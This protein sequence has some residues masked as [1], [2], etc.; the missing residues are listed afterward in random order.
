MIIRIGLVL[1]FLVIMVVSIRELQNKMIFM[2][3]RDK[4]KSLNKIKKIIDKNVEQHWIKT[5]DNEKL[6]SLYFKNN[7]KDTIIIYCHGNAGNI[8]SRLHMINVLKRYGS[9]LLFDYRGYGKSSGVPTEL[10]LKKDI[11]AVW[12]YTK[13]ELGYPAQNVVLYGE[14]LGC[15]PT[16]WLGKERKASDKPKCLILQSGFSCLKDIVSDIGPKFLENFLIYDFDNLELIKSIKADIPILIIHSPSDEIININHA[17]RL[18]IANR[19]VNFLRI[20]GTHNEPVFDD[21]YFNGIEK[22]INTKI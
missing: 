15:F 19:N 13:K 12:N 7:T 2:P 17:F 3:D 6:H 22:L 4:F 5:K 16:L 8:Y 20:H 10:G 18:I 14:S 1:I 11:M 9:I 21:N